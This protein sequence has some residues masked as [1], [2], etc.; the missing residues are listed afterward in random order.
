M[1]T[2]TIDQIAADWLAL[3]ARADDIKWQRGRLAQEASKIDQL[4]DLARRVGVDPKL[5]DQYRRI[6]QD[7]P[8]QVEGLSWSAHRELSYGGRGGDVE[9]ARRLI[10]EGKTTVS[11]IAAELGRKD[12]RGEGEVRRGLDLLPQERRED[13]VRDVVQ[14]DPERFREMIDRLAPR[15]KAEPTEVERREIVRREVAERPEIVREVLRDQPEVAEEVVRHVAQTPQGRDTL[16]KITSD[17]TTRYLNQRGVTTPRQRPRT[18]F[19]DTGEEIVARHELVKASASIR[20]AYAAL[21]DVVLDE[22]IKDRLIEDVARIDRQLEVLRSRITNGT[23]DEELA[24]FMQAG[25]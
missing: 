22:E 23:I 10:A 3:D 25:S 5:L 1:S 7:W 13:I 24:R 11:L 9:F 21:A 18:E 4:V 19:D 15:P 16:R 14:V 12:P 8:T 2:R 17:E 20:A 6:G